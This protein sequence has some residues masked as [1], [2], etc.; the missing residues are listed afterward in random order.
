MFSYQRLSRAN[1]GA[2]VIGAVVNELL[3]EILFFSVRLSAF[4]QISKHS[5]ETRYR[6]GGPDQAG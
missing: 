5:A 4:R 1:W 6:D 2:I 3:S